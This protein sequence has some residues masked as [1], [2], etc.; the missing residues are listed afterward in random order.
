MEYKWIPIT[1]DTLPNLGE[2]VLWH[3]SD[4]YTFEYKI[5]PLQKS[6]VQDDYSVDGSPLKLYDYWMYFKMT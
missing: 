4:K 5:A 6:L 1:K 3:S 2:N